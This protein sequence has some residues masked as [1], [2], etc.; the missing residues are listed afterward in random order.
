[1]NLFIALL[2]VAT[3]FATSVN[4]R[5]EH[6]HGDRIAA[7]TA[8]DAYFASSGKLYT[9]HGP[10][11]W[12]A[13]TLRTIKNS[14][15]AASS[16]ERA[17]ALVSPSTVG[18]RNKRDEKPI[19]I[20]ATINGKVVS[21]ETDPENLLAAPAAPAM[22][23]GLASSSVIPVKLQ[24]SAYP[25]SSPFQGAIPEAAVQTA[26]TATGIPWPFPIG[27]EQGS[28]P[29]G[30]SSPTSSSFRS[31]ASPPCNEKQV[32]SLVD[33]DDLPQFTV[34]DDPN[35]QDVPPIFNPY[36]KLYF[37]DHFGYVPP[38]SDPYPPRSSPQLAVYRVSGTA[39]DGSPNA[40]LVTGGFG[41]GPRAADNSYWYV[42][43]SNST[44]RGIQVV[45]PR[46]MVQGSF[47][48]PKCYD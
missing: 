41:A 24:A 17:S 42:K 36:R 9:G 33:F 12:N 31:T 14:T 47:F 13:T 11:G 10:E 28:S 15:A 1:M 19:V 3:A 32:A 38:P 44:P 27:P 7:A 21:W 22:A 20:T 8:P 45:G 23:E 16:V 2:L 46:D 34:S 18:N 30:F 26:S 37:D 6:S 25:I 29:E 35:D 40:G 48:D 4:L 39:T 43:S 5:D